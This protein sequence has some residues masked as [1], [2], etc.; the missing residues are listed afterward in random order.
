MLARSRARVVR[1]LRK[2]DAF[3][4]EETW[5]KEAPGLNCCGQIVDPLSDEAARFCIQGALIKT[6]PGIEGAAFRLTMAALHRAACDVSH[7][8]YTS[9]FDMNDDPKTE[10]KHIKS[11]LARTIESLEASSGSLS[12]VEAADL[13]KRE[14]SLHHDRDAWV[15]ART[16]SQ[17]HDLSVR[18]LAMALRH[19]GL[20]GYAQVSRDGHDARSANTLL[21]SQLFVRLTLQLRWQGAQQELAHYLSELTQHLPDVWIER[22]RGAANLPERPQTVQQSPLDRVLSDVLKE[23]RSFANV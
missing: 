17:R 3:L 14:A 10:L 23:G 11:V 12:D 5:A 4:T 9:I 20:M 7:N 15:L 21:A 22:I 8:K 13:E 2:V 18:T 6:T 19:A 1:A 16:Y